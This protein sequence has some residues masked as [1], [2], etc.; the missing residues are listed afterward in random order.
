VNT[1]SIRN[2]V[3][4]AMWCA[5]LQVEHLESRAS[6]SLPEGVSGYGVG[7]VACVVECATS[8]EFRESGLWTPVASP[9]I[10]VSLGRPARRSHPFSNRYRWSLNLDVPS[11]GLAHLRQGA[12]VQLVEF[13]GV[14]AKEDTLTAK[15][16]HQCAPDQYGAVISLTG[17]DVLLQWTI[18]GPRKDYRL[19]THYRPSV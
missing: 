19:E 18:R 14:E 1:N 8:V 11:I 6:G 16:A 15:A 7:D 17:H 3:I 5:L 2:D 10:D 9:N 12:P 13:T 4:E